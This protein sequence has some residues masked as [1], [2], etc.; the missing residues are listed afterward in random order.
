MHSVS[1]NGVFCDSHS[2]LHKDI[3]S[4][5][6]PAVPRCPHIVGFICTGVHTT[7]WFVVRKAVRVRATNVLTQAVT[8]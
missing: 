6:P 3:F 7:I 1:P 8:D 4:Y 5:L 2:K